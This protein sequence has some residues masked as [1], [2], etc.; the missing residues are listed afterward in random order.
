MNSGSVDAQDLRGF[1]NR[2]QFPEK[3]DPSASARPAPAW[4]HDIIICSLLKTLAL[5]KTFVEGTAGAPRLFGIVAISFAHLNQ[6]MKRE[7]FQKS[8]WVPVSLV[9]LNKTLAIIP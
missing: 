6:S 3:F 5:I 2:R 7:R 1:A 4:V 8:S 9:H